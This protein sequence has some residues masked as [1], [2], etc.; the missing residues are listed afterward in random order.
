M[1][2]DRN[3]RNNEWVKWVEECNVNS[4]ELNQIEL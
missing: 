2:Y 3:G 1:D 4:V